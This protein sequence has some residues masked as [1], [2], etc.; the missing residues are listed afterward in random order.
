MKSTLQLTSSH[1]CDD[2][3]LVVTGEPGVPITV[4]GFKTSVGPP[5]LRSRTVN[6]LNHHPSSGLEVRRTKV[7]V[8]VEMGFER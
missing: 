8:T 7:S 4:I 2:Q 5:R 6:L 1:K 3:T